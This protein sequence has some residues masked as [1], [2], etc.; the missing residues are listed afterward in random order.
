ML[1]LLH[2]KS[3]VISLEVEKKIL[4]YIFLVG[5]HDKNNRTFNSNRAKKILL[6]SSKIKCTVLLRLSFYVWLFCQVRK[7]ICIF[8]NSICIRGKKKQNIYL[9]SISTTRYTKRVHVYSIEAKKKAKSKKFFFSSSSST[10]RETLLTFVVI[11]TSFPNRLVCNKNNK[12]NWWWG[13]N[14]S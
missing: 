11:F 14:M 6:N 13:K 1:L 7:P 12:K 8:L 5:I 4:S 3:K 2:T 10:K 9:K